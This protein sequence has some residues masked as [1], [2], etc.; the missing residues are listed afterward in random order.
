MT[1]LRALGLGVAVFMCQSLPGHAEI[2]YQYYGET[3]GW[4][5]SAVTFDGQFMRCAAAYGGD[6]AL[7]LHYSSEGY[8]VVMAG[9]SAPQEVPGSLDIDR[10][11]FE[12]TW[13]AGDSGLIWF[14]DDLT[15]TAL[16]QGSELTANAAGQPQMSIG[17]DG[18]A[19]ALLKLEECVG[20][21][22]EAKAAAASPAP[23]PKPAKPAEPAERKIPAAVVQWPANVPPQPVENETQ[24]LGANCPAW[25]EFASGA[26]TTAAR[27]SFTNNSDGAVSIYWI[28]FD[29]TLTEYAG[30]LPGETFDVDTYV[31]HVWVAKDFEGTCLGKG[32]LFPRKGKP[33]RFNLK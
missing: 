10:A 31:G 18:S 29:G 33:N 11:S 4:M 16:R 20:R 1:S 32:A 21:G 9:V 2:G 17:L 26:S 8:T 23:V 24:Y 25:G 30:L 13:F 15:L 3:K 14:M 6:S 28:G 19:A 22:G 27:A 12:G 5:V 7:E